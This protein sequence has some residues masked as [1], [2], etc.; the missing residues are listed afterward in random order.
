MFSYAIVKFRVIYF[1]DFYCFLIFDVIEKTWDR[2]FVIFSEKTRKC[3]YKTCFFDIFRLFWQ[4]LGFLVFS[5]LL[6]LCLESV[7]Q[8]L[9]AKKCYSSGH[10]LT[11]KARSRV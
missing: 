6:I 9:E 5:T 8:A 4:K 3:V 7:I 10:P 1:F 2:F 11:M